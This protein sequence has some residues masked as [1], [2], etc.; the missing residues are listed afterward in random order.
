MLSQEIG[1]GTTLLHYRISEQI[2]SGGMGVVWKAVDTKLDREVALK[3]LRPDKCGDS[4]W[5]KRLVREAKCASALQHPGIVAIHDV[6]CA[7]EPWFIVM[8]YVGGSS[9]RQLL[10]QQRLDSR[11]ALD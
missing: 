10:R 2:G 3:L 6:Q 11:R 5:R 1:P 9:L 7:D 4:A 8:E